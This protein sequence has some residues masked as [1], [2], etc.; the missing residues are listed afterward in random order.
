MGT[1]DPEE[2]FFKAEHFHF[3]LKKNLKKS[4][5]ASILLSIYSM[6]YK[7]GN[8]YLLCAKSASGNEVINVYCPSV[9][10]STPPCLQPFIT[11]FPEGA[12]LWCTLNKDGAALANPRGDPINGYH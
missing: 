5:Q 10:S 6:I 1:R 12:D 7:V 8:L 11:Q 3:V 4:H 9:N 2:E